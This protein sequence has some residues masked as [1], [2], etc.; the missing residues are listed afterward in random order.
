MGGW[1][2]P[3]D[4]H[5]REFVTKPATILH[6]GAQ[7]VGYVYVHFPPSRTVVDAPLVVKEGLRNEFRQRAANVYRKSNKGYFMRVLTLAE[8][9]QVSGGC[10]GGSRRRRR[11]NSCGSRG[12]SSSS[13]SSRCGT[14]TGCTTAPAPAPAPAVVEVKAAAP[15]MRP[16]ND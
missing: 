10:G 6:L 9:D 3:T 11:S 1:V 13:G 15:A 12:N 2:F 14:N 7:R 16:P 5:F 4:A 8:M